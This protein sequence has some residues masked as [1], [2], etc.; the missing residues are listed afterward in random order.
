MLVIRCIQMCGQLYWAVLAFPEHD[1]DNNYE[2]QEGED[3]GLKLLVLL[4]EM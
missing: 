4:E 1:L 3:E 2:V